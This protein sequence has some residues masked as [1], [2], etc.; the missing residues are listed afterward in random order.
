MTEDIS[1][2]PEDYISDSDNEIISIDTVDTSE[3]ILQPP[4]DPDEILIK[5][6]AAT[7][8]VD[9]PLSNKT[10][11]RICGFNKKEQLMAEVYMDKKF[12]NS[13]VYMFD[14]MIY[15]IITDNSAHS[16]ANKLYTKIKET[17]TENVTYKII[18]RDDPLVLNYMENKDKWNLLSTSPEKGSRI[19]SNNKIFMAVKGY[20]LKSMLLHSKTKYGTM[21]HNYMLKCESVS[22]AMFQYFDYIRIVNKTEND[23]L[24]L[25]MVPMN[26]IEERFARMAEQARITAHRTQESF[27]LLPSIRYVDGYVYLLK[28]DA[29]QN[30]FVYKFGKTI[31]LE[32]RLSSY[33]TGDKSVSFIKTWKVIDCH[34]AE[35]IILNAMSSI[36][37]DDKSEWLIVYN[38]D[39]IITKI[40]KLVETINDT[41]SDDMLAE[42]RNRYINNAELVI[43]KTINLI[44][45]TSIKPKSPRYK[46]DSDT[47][48]S[49]AKVCSKQL[50]KYKQDNK[51]EKFKRGQKKEAISN[52]LKQNKTDTDNE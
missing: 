46:T 22:S 47:E 13:W 11:L 38:E 16:A 48:Q 44:R 24:M 27:M 12:N 28:S 9:S 25:Q 37:V 30:N 40:N 21:M 42:A 35:R 32:S 31:N 49:D 15:P 20:V 43:P 18:T 6:Q 1:K 29:G 5:L 4:M 23:K 10:I 14:E 41:L 19:F 45:S 3:T 2:M 8:R 39:K 50:A 26:E 51:I 34:I 17:Y 36:R 7:R 33:K 52:I